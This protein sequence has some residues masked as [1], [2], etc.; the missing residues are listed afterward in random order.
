MIK[1]VFFC[2]AKAQVDDPEGRFWLVL[3]GTDRL[4]ELF[5]IV[6]TMVGNNVNVD[7]LQL[8]ERI[9][10]ATEVSTILALYPHWDTPPRRLKLPALTRDSPVIHDHVDHLKPASWKGDIRV[11]SVDSENHP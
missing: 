7:V 11:S 1:N 9:T 8:G 6:R 5:G 3:L 4:E 2:V 10:S